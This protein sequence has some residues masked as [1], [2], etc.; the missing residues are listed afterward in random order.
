LQ[1]MIVLG[2]AAFA[3]L[4]AG[5]EGRAQTPNATAPAAPT[6]P[7]SAK[8]LQDWRRGMARVP[9]PKKGCFTSSYPSTQ[10]QEIPCV[11][12]PA[13]PYPPARG[14]RPDTIG[15]GNDA[16]AQVTGLISEA[17]GSFDSVTGVTSVTDP[18][19]TSGFSLQLNTS[20]FTTTACNG[21][22]NP[23]AC[24]GWQQFVYSNSGI[25]FIQYWLVDYNTTCPAGWNTFDSGPDVDCW[26]NGTNAASVPIQPITNLVALSLTGQASQGGTDTIIMATGSNVYSAQNEDNVL[27]LAQAWQAAEFNILGDCCGSETTFNS[28]STVVVRTSV[29]YGSPSAP[30]C[31]GQG[32]TRET[33]NLFFV[34]ASVVPPSELL[35][36]VVFTQSSATSTTSPCN[37]ATGVA[38]KEKQAATDTHDFNGDGKSDILWRDISGDAAV[39]LMNG[40]QTIQAG[41]VGTVPVAVWSIVGQRDF[42][43]DGKADLLWRDTSGNIAMWFMNG[44]AV[45]ESVSVGN[46]PTSWSIVGTADFNGDGYGDILWQDNT[47]N[48]A[49]WL[50]QGSSILQGGVLGNVG[51]SWTVAGTA[52][53]NGDGNADILWKDNAG[54]VA[55][56]LMNGVSVSQSGG[57]G[58][59]GTSWNVVGTGDFNGDGKGD[60]LWM[61]NAGNVAIWLMNGLSI[62]QAEAIT[63]VGP[64]WNVAVTGDF[65][66]DGKSDILWR[67]TS[68]NV[69]MWFMNG[70]TISEAVGLGNISTSWTIQGLNAD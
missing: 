39:W 63:N 62:S 5:P 12:A 26:Q 42:N 7:P 65:S 52:D 18:N 32:F 15:N 6:V 30:S 70:L 17:V 35:P 67:D 61:D 54:N 25:A 56:W 47:G 69:A 24:L 8:N 33:N 3:A 53:F 48:V 4:L 38:A 66:G 16:S 45:A 2:L 40:T 10:W 13:R 27:D 68:G 55:I 21:S 34:Q 20:F 41:V 46:V 14:P 22:A 28:G 23:S 1:A 36:A 19:G 49:I 50:M 60:V 43:G 58:N 59:V 44:L 37:S 9:L 11:T 57:L 64:S 29:D 31:L 51:T